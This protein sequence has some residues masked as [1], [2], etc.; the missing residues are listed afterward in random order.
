MSCPTRPG[1]ADHDGAPEDVPFGLDGFDQSHPDVAL[2]AQAITSRLFTAGY[3]LC[4]VLGMTNDGPGRTRLEHAV[5]E[6][7]EAIKDLRHLMLTLR[8]HAHD[9]PEDSGAADGS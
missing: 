6:V 2:L 5:S 1:A 9:F 4:C 3:D 7:D 8:E